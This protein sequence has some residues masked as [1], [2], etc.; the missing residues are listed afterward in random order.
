[1]V[2]FLVYTAVDQ[3]QRS[4]SPGLYALIGVPFLM[5]FCDAVGT[6]ISPFEDLRP[7]PLTLLCQ[8]FFVQI[9]LRLNIAEASRQDLEAMTDDDEWSSF[10]V[11]SSFLRRVITTYR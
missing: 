10:M 5:I 4:G 3:A 1:M 9:L 8:I 2:V 11:Q 6:F 7:D